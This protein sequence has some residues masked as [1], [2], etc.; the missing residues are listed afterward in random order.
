MIPSDAL[1]FLYGKCRHT[2]WQD[3]VVALIRQLGVYPPGSL[4]Q[5]SDQKLGIVTVN[6]EQ[7]LR[8]IILVYDDQGSRMNQQC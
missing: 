4:V 3:A 6:S 2:L 1:S 8:P 7:R 5:L